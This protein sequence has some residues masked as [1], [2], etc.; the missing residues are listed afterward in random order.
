MVQFC[1][2][3]ICKVA[4]TDADGLASF[5]DPEGAYEVHILKVPEGYKGTDEVFKTE[6]AYG[7]VNI[8]IE[9]E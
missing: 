8:T 1:T 4:P 7:D 5:D 6:A 3:E 2:D 9:K